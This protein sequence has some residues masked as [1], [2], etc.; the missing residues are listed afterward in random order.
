[1]RCK[2]I[3]FQN[4]HVPAIS[5]LLKASAPGRGL[6]REVK[7]ALLGVPPVN[8]VEGPASEPVE[9]RRDDCDD[10]R[11][12]F[13]CLTSSTAWLK[14]DG[15]FETG[16]SARRH[17]VIQGCRRSLRAE[18][19]R[20]GSFWKHCIRKSRAACIKLVNLVE[21]RNMAHVQRICPQ[22]EEGGRR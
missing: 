15:A 18:T 12:L 13:H 16:A 8:R 6:A 4:C 20:L 11:A 2:R 5:G 17:P 1:L 19:R 10:L 22:E 7:G 14:L 21:H 9:A 3:E